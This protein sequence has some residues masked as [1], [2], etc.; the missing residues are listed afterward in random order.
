MFRLRILTPEGIYYDNDVSS[1]NIKSID[2]RRTLLPNH[3]PLVMPTD[4]G[5]LEIRDGQKENRYF[6]FDGILTFEKNVANLMVTVIERE[7]KIDFVRA[8]KARQRA[9][10]RI[11]NKQDSVDLIRAEAAL[12]RAIERLRLE[13]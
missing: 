8:E 5:V 10:N 2:G 12:R 4:L 6:A 7:D 11:E 13:E 1:I 9:L 3:M